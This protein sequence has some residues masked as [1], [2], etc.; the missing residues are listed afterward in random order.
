[1]GCL[2]G[3]KIANMGFDIVL[4]VSFSHRNM[5][6]FTIK[7]L[8]L[9]IKFRKLFVITNKKNF[10]FF[11]QYLSSNSKVILLDEDEVILDVNFDSIKSY[12]IR[13]IKE[14][15]R[16]GWYFQQFLKMGICNYSELSEYYLIWD[17][18]TLLLKEMSFLDSQGRMNIYPKFEYHKP[19]F[20]CM[21]KLIGFKK[22]VDFSFISEHMLIK[23]EYM[24]ELISAI[25]E[26]KLSDI[27]WTE[28]I[29]NTIDDFNLCGSGFSEYE[30]YGNYVFN[31]YKD[32]FNICSFKTLRGGASCFGHKVSVYDLFYLK[33]KNYITVSFESWMNVSK[34]KVCVNKIKTFLFYL[35]VNLFH[36]NSTRV[37]G[38]FELVK[39][40]VNKGT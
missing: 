23:K 29:L 5:A 15:N 25:Y 16:A 27:S 19:Y 36:F 12:F 10:S 34:L 39:D 8:H 33:E 38:S 21:E 28:H 18:D 11:N 31:K 30:T 1:M 14:G 4:C 35:Y 2:R 7:S 37:K 40:I 6:L 24:K 9:F 17:S 26:Y 20:D 22:C 3:G 13:R 32:N